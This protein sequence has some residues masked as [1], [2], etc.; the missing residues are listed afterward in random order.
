MVG[1]MNFVRRILGGGEAEMGDFSGMAQG[2]KLITGSGYPFEQELPVTIPP[3]DPIYRTKGRV[4]ME[5]YSFV[6]ANAVVL[7]NVTIGEGA[8]VGANSVAWKNI[9]PWTIVMGN[10]ARVVGKHEKWK[11]KPSA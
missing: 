11:P 2:A 1:E 4:V 9:P 6:A 5:T 7:P 3:G 10:P 8:I